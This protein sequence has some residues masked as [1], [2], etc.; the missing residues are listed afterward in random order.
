MAYLLDTDTCIYA[1][2]RRPPQV[3]QRLVD[4]LESDRSLVAISSITLS[5]LEY[6]VEKSSDPVRNRL[7]LVKFLM[8]MTILAYGPEAAAYGWLCALL[9]RRGRP[10][11]PLDLLVAAHALF[12]EHTLVTNNEREF[13]RVPGLQIENWAAQSPSRPGASGG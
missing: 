10:I 13:R 8:P 11:G 7:A 2:K 1:I 12:A 3:T 5:E 4:A 9:E 6:D